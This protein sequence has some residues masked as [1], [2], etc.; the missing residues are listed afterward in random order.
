MQIY[1][2]RDGEQNGPYSIEDVNAYLKDGTL[3]PTDLACQEGMDEWVQISQIPDVTIHGD[4]VATQMASSQPV[5]NGKKKKI[6]IGVGASTGLLALVAVIWFFFIGETGEEDSFLGSYD[7]QGQEKIHL[8]KNSECEWEHFAAAGKLK[9]KWKLVGKEVH[10]KD[11]NEAAGD[12]P[13]DDSTSVYIL[14]QNSDL[15]QI[16]HINEEG[17]RTDFPKDEQPTYKKIK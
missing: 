3:L 14:N 16:A 9:Q 1:I 2:S 11:W 13:S 4:P 7:F 10:I 8:L 5:P 6:L 15:T 12:S 17:E